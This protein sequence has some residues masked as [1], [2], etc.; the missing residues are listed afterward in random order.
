MAAY[1]GGYLLREE[2][3]GQTLELRTLLGTLVI[4]GQGYTDAIPEDVGGDPSDCLEWAFATGPI[5]ITRSEPFINPPS[6][7]EALDTSTNIVTFRAER[8]YR[9]VWDTIL[10]AGVLI[11]R[12]LTG[13]DSLEVS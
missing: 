5:E 12:N 8:Y 2:K 11:D 1:W 6:Y 4:P 9:V 7:A 13:C 10:Q 3:N